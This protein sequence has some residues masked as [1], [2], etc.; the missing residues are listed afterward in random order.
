MASQVTEDDAR[1]EM[2]ASINECIIEPLALLAGLFRCADDDI[3]PA[4]LGSL[5]GLVVRGARE[6]LKIHEDGGYGAKMISDL[7]SSLEKCAAAE[8]S[9][10][11]QEGR[12]A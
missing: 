1:K 6:E 4:P 7:L 8:D 10:S 3:A 11:S 2:A 12:H 5:M 9:E